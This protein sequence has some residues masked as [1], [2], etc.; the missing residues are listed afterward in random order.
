M[1]PS[2]CWGPGLSAPLPPSWLPAYIK[3]FFKFP[4]LLDKEY[5]SMTN[6]ISMFV[7]FFG[8]FARKDVKHVS[9]VKNTVALV[10]KWVPWKL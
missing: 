4:F 1:G 8:L 7:V 6:F 5:S 2:K 10:A 9:I 3:Q